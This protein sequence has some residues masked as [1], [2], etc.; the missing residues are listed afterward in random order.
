MM[1][2]MLAMCAIIGGKIFTVQQFQD[3][4]WI[5]D[6]DSEGGSIELAEQ[7]LLI[8]MAEDLRLITEP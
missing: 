7:E 5:T 1:C 4:G 3:S 2:A 8:A 6:E